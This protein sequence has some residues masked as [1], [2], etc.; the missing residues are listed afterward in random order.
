MIA[1][2]AAEVFENPDHE[3]WPHVFEPGDMVM[4]MTR[5]GKAG[6]KRRPDEVI[7][8][9]K[10][11][12]PGG[13][14]HEHCCLCGATISARGDNLRSGSTDGHDW[15]CETWYAERIAPHHDEGHG[16]S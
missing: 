3:W 11:V 12:V 16:D 5:R 6:H 2:R 7:A 8:E 15:A 10:N 9:D 1:K 4:V 14:D 13:W